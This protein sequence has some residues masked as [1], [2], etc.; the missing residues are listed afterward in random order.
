M[1]QVGQRAE[2]ALELVDLLDVR[3][4]DR[5]ERHLLAALDVVGLV[6]HAHATGADP[7]YHLVPIDGAGDLLHR[8]GPDATPTIRRAGAARAGSSGRP[9]RESR[10]A[11]RVAGARGPAGTSMR[12]A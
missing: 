12:A 5:L 7:P 9:W 8:S 11:G 6:D 3:V 10:S 4:G 1:R 2:L